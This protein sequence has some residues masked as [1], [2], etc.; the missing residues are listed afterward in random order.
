VLNTLVLSK[1][2][3]DESQTYFKA[4]RKLHRDIDEILNYILPIYYLYRHSLELILKSVILTQVNT[5]HNEISNINHI[6]AGISVDLICHSLKKLFEYYLFFCPLERLGILITD[7]QI[8][9]VQ[10]T[11]KYIDSFDD[12]GDFSRY[13]IKTNLEKSH[14]PVEFYISESNPSVS[15]DISNTQN[16]FLGFD[17]SGYIKYFILHNLDI[18][19]EFDNIARVIRIFCGLTEF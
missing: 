17:G 13:P 8:Q 14:A 3:Y 11:I 5:Y 6:R 2:F 4:A 12:R 19:E 15:P 1:M 7:E 18:T 9:L 10:K 16:I